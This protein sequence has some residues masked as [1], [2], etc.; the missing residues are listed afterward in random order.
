MKIFLIL[1]FVLFAN[2]ASTHPVIFKGGWVFQGHYFDDS[3]TQKIGYSF[4]RKSSIE[5]NSSFYKG[6][7]NQR[8]YTLG[9]NYLFKRWLNNDSQGN[10]YGSMHAGVY[11]DDL[12]KNNSS[13]YHLGLLG[14]WES[15]KLFTKGSFKLLR[16]NNTIK[17]KIMSC[18]GFAPYVAGMDTLQTW[19]ITQ[20]EY[21]KQ[22][23]KNVV[24][25]P[26]FR[27][28]YKNVLWELGSPTT[29]GMFLTLMLHY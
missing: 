20:F 10:L 8:D 15:R 24:V 21:Y 5:V 23:S 9:F 3:N 16:Y 2:I 26:K 4:S 14:D 1:T 27:F 13:M 19:F 25:V 29:G 28:F 18:F 7:F 17:Y 11:T 12:I 6:I 22:E